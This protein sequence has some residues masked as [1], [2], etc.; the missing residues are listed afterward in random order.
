MTLAR[1]PRKYPYNPSW[2]HITRMHCIVLVYLGGM[3]C[4]WN[5]SLTRSSGDT[6]VRETAP[7][8]PPATRDCH[9]GRATFQPLLCGWDAGAGGEEAA[10]DGAAGE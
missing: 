3:P 8:V 2:R 9:E 6:R 10:M 5:S 4:I 7:A 1:L